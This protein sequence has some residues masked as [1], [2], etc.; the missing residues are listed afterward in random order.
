MLLLLVLCRILYPGSKKDN[1]KNRN[2][3]F[4]KFD[5]SLKDIYRALD[6]FDEYKEDIQKV[7]QKKNIKEICQLA[8]SIALII[9]LK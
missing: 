2:K 8:F 7:I 3:F 9:I 5:F 1:Y 4:E 6:F